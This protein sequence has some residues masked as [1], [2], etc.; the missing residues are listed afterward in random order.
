MENPEGEEPAM[1]GEEGY[2]DDF[3]PEIGEMA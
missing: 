2:E 1:E 3:E